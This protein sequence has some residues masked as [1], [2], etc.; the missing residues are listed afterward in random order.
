MVINFLKLTFSPNAPEL[1]IEKS[2]IRLEVYHPLAELASVT[3]NEMDYDPSV[4]RL[5]FRGPDIPAIR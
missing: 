3:S 2:T 5:R 4:G 1:A